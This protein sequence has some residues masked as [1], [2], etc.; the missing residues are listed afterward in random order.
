[1][2]TR[3]RR[4]D[5]LV[6]VR[7]GANSLHLQTLLD[8]PGRSWDCFISWYVTPSHTGGAE[9][10]GSDGMN[11][12]D[13]FVIASESSLRDH[14]YR[15]VLLL[16]DDIRFKPGDISR[17]F[18]ICERERLHLCQP[19]LTWGTNINHPVTL[20]NPIC[21]VREV[22]FVEV[23]APCFSREA[24]L[25]LL[26]SFRLTVSTWGVDYAWAA[27]LK[28]KLPLTVVDAVQVDHI[29]E[30]DLADGP[31]YRYM[32]GMGVD[33]EQECAEVVRKISGMPVRAT[34]GDDH[35]YRWP[36]PQVVNRRLMWLAE[37]LKMRGHRLRL[38]RRSAHAPVAVT[39]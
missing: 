32:K 37:T 9:Y 25:A 19:S 7:A 35:R 10:Q 8:D 39:R 21:T 36:L 34:T 2:D 20:W 27:L 24:L 13:A 23:M 11:K 1:M 5:H 30:V 28:D 33:P 15:Y 14:A 22:G 18:A 38:K 3:T 29:K 16:D 31:F 6:F 12:L 4:R 17:L 26:P